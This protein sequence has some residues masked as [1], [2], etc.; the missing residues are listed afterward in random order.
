MEREESELHELL[1]NFRIR[2]EWFERAA[3]VA[4]M[5]KLDARILRVDEL[6]ITGQRLVGIRADK[7]TIATWA[8]KAKTAGMSLNKWA[9]LVLNS[10]PQVKPA[11]IVEAPKSHG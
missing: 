7:K 4:E 5:K 8:R 6:P 11:T 10:A 2:R 3:V 9:H 1:N